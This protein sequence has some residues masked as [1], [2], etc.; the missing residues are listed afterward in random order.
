MKFNF[1]ITL[2]LLLYSAITLAEVKTKSFNGKV[3]NPRSISACSKES[4]GT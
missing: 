1:I 2:L 4:S 3:S